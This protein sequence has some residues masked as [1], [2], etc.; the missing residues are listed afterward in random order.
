MLLKKLT[1]HGGHY[2]NG[3]Y[4]PGFT[5][6][7]MEDGSTRF[8]GDMSWDE[9]IDELKRLGCNCDSVVANLERMCKSQLPPKPENAT[10]FQH[11]Y[12]YKPVKEILEWEWST[13]FGCWGAVVVFEGED[14]RVYT[15]PKPEWS[16]Q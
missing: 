9:S 15:Y 12:G 6:A 4:S 8:M 1:Y 11:G 3:F 16:K 5:T 7:T 10:H 2:N 13:T 14:H